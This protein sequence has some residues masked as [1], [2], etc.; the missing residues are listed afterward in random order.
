MRF[1][2]QKM[3]SGVLA[4]GLALSCLVGPAFAASIKDTIDTGITQI[5][6]QEK[7]MAKFTDMMPGGKKHWSYDFVARMVQDGLFAG[8]SATTFSPNVAMTE[9][10]FLT[11]V[12][13]KAY[14]EELNQ[15][16]AEFGSQGW[17]MGAYQLGLDKGIISKNI[18]GTDTNAFN[19]R[20]I[21]RERMT[22]MV[23]KAMESKG[24]SVQSNVSGV[25]SRVPDLN[26]CSDLFKMSVIK[27]YSTGIIAGDDKGNM[28]P[29]KT[30]TRAEGATV[31]YRFAYPEA[32]TAPDFSKPPV[33]NPEQG[34][35]QTWN[36]G[37]T[38]SIPKVGDTVI[39]AD[40]TKVVLK[41]TNGILGF[42]Q[43]VDIITGTTING[44]SAK[45][46]MMSWYDQTKFTKCPITG[47]MYSREQW[48]DIA[49]FTW[50]EGL[51]GEY[52][53]EVYNTYYKWSSA[54]N[55]WLWI[56]PNW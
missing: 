8:T 19:N 40:G 46:G 34:Q 45:E 37:Q 16:N 5:E 48:I 49:D 6:Q 31:L 12:L 11:V 38:H 39:K 17:F 4:T 20:A 7:I 47:E 23:I 36:E 43:G 21:T 14:P 55:Y 1:N 56:G 24:E 3:L 54:E 2:K 53:G 26:K 13:R 52:D 10:Q 18:Y 51:V 41:E 44:I 32:R 33:T 9:S 28:N 30:A 29:Q 35:N 50:P 42:G 15:Y 27:A 22:D 25:T